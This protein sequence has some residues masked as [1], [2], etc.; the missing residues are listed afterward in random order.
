MIK[1]ECEFEFNYIYQYL[2]RVLYILCIL[3]SI[4]GMAQN[5]QIDSLVV[6]LKIVKE[7][8]NK[9][10]ILYQLSDE[11]MDDKDVLHYAEESLELAEKL[12]YKKGIANAS[13]NIGYVFMNKGDLANALEWY[14]KSLIIQKEIGDK[15]GIA[16]SHNNIGLIYNNQ[17]NI[18]KALECFIRSLKI[19][20]EIGDK[21]GIAHSLNNIGGI[22]YNQGNISS[23]LDWFQKSLKIREEIGDKHGIATSLINIGAIYDDQGNLPKAL[24]WYYKSLTLQKEIGDKLGIANS[25]GPGACAVRCLEH[26]LSTRTQVYLLLS[27]ASFFIYSKN[28]NFPKGGKL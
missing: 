4:G 15:L 21:E 13:N 8:T 10:N 28:T 24:E 17:G 7:D 18:P 20:E 27:A 23:A 22:Y 3:F 11:S 14:Y 19:Q 9:V 16:T 2:K 1:F 6:V 5:K 26:F 12:N 25:N